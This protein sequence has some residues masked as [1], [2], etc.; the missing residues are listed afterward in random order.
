MRQS[1]DYSNKGVATYFEA[2]VLLSSVYHTIPHIVYRRGEHERRRLINIVP[3]LSQ[4]VDIFKVKYV[5]KNIS[6][7]MLLQREDFCLRYR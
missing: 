4:N 2:K 7:T 3:V 5:W 1:I 6:D